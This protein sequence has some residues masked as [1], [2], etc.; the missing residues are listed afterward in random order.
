[1]VKQ[2]TQPP[3]EKSPYSPLEISAI[4]DRRWWSYMRNMEMGT[5][6]GEE[7]R[8]YSYY[9]RIELKEL[10]KDKERI[11]EELESIDQD[12]AQWENELNGQ[13]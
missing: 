13:S 7:P 3:G 4:R 6:P 2:P 8:P 12:I 11:L 5:P 9:R 10:L 1:M